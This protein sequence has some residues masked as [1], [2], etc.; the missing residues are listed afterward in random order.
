MPASRPP[1]SKRRAKTAKAK[2][3][4]PRKKSKNA[5]DE[6]TWEVEYI[7]KA[8]VKWR[9][10]RGLYWEY[11][12]KWLGWTHDHDTWEGDASFVADSDIVEEF[13]LEIDR[14][15]V[16]PREN[17]NSKDIMYEGRT[18]FPSEEWIEEYKGL[19]IAATDMPLPAAPDPRAVSPF[20]E[21]Q[22]Q[23]PVVVTATERMW[24]QAAHHLDDDPD[25][26][27]ESEDRSG[28]DSDD[29][30]YQEPNSFAEGP[31]NEHD[32]E[33][34][35]GPGL[36]SA[37]AESPSRR[38]YA[39]IPDNPRHYYRNMHPPPRDRTPD[40]LE[41]PN[42]LSERTRESRMQPSTTVF[43]HP[44][45][46]ASVLRANKKR[47]L[48]THRRGPVSQMPHAVQL[49]TREEY[50]AI[51]RRQYQLFSS[52]LEGTTS[53]AEEDRDNSSEEE[54]A[55]PNFFNG[56]DAGHASS[57]VLSDGEIPEAE[58][59]GQ[60]A[61]FYDADEDEGDMY[62][63]DPPASSPVPASPGP[64]SPTTP[65][66]ARLLLGPIPEDPM[67]EVENELA[68]AG[69]PESDCMDEDTVSPAA[70][71]SLNIEELINSDYLGGPGATL[72][73]TAWAPGPVRLRSEDSTFSS[74]A[75]AT[76]EPA[77]QDREDRDKDMAMEVD[78]ELEEGEIRQ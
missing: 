42:A 25:S 12:V 54:D 52:Q 63:E 22:R 9:S 36:D 31:Y 56:D 20:H 75:T 8:R 34:P 51:E 16:N 37:H 44:D 11:Y 57:P 62:A 18:V 66:A 14:S 24:Q 17:A 13:W 7:L 27:S 53:H 15:Y 30:D 77:G 76:A 60:E 33:Y 1:K 3:R 64:S 38:R 41:T 40:I 71:P 10:G 47:K 6:E 70:G 46:D 43:L 2:K 65:T 19:A 73:A 50:E 74:T 32:D 5:E 49:F 58:E 29:D 26:H 69:I 4:K 48:E 78:S 23:A 45:R 59:G 68:L 61:L 55:G 35:T 28:D 67:E 21:E 39:E 72:S